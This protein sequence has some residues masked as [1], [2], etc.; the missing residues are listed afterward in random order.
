MDPNIEINTSQEFV[1]SL[2]HGY[3]ILI[4]R[5]IVKGNKYFSKTLEITT[6]QMEYMEQLGFIGLATRGGICF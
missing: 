2:F 5:G 3:V 6:I 1:S 4:V